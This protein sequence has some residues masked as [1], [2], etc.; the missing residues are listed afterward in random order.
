MSTISRQS[1]ELKRIFS[2][3]NDLL[4]EACHLVVC[5]DKPNYIAN[6][7][8]VCP[9][10]V[11]QEDL[12]EMKK[13]RQQMP[14]TEKLQ[15]CRVRLLR[16]NTKSRQVKIMV[17]ELAKIIGAINKGTVFLDALIARL[18]AHLRVSGKSQPATNCT[19]MSML[20]KSK[21]AKGGQ[22]MIAKTKET[23]TI[24]R[25]PKNNP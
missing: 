10:S 9:H 19:T 18:E 5:S 21:T 23:K 20:S 22:T 16:M 25:A 13:L 2:E 6:K 12:Q 24:N 11:Q 7:L 3:A 17:Y 15:S 4:A 14:T 1:L 8:V